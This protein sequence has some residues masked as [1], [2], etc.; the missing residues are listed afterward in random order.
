MSRHRLVLALLACVLTATA[1]AARQV[2]VPLHFDH[3]LIRQALVAQLYTS[4]S[5]KAILWDDGTGCGF[6]KLREPAVNSAGGR[7]RVVTRGEAR[8][9]TP[10]G[11]QCLA[12]LQWDGFIEVL[13]DPQISTD[14][15]VLQFRVVESNVYDQ[16]LKKRFVTG[17]L[18]DIVKRYVQPRFEA[19]RIDL[20]A[21]AADLRDVLPLIVARGDAERIASILDSIHLADATVNDTGVT[22]AL[23][24]AVSDVAP[25]AGPTPEPTLTAT[26]LQRWEEAW[27]RWDAFLTFVVKQLGHDTAATDLH[28]AL[29]DVLVDAR[30]D[31]LEALAP[32]QPGEPDP[33]RALFLKTWERLAPVVKRSAATM[34]GTAALRY[35]SFIAAGDALAALDQMGPDVGLDISAD[36]LR[37]LARIV[38]PLN[39]EDPLAYTTAVDPDLRQLFGFG[40]PLPPPD[41]SD[42]PTDQAW[43]HQLLGSTR[44]FAAE[45]KPSLKGL[46][47]WIADREEID[48]YLQA[49]HDVL[50]ETAHKTLG[51]SNLEERYRDV[52][53][54]LVLAA[55]WQESCWRQ[56]VRANGKVTYMKSAVGS[57]GM[58]QVNEHVWRGFYDLR[59]LRWDIHYNGRAGAEILMRYLQDYAIAHDEDKQPGGI[60]NLARATY[61]VYNGGPGQLTRY[62]KKNEKKTLQRIDKLF[63]EKYQAVSAG[64]EMDVSR[65]IVGG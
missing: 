63:W 33:T 42:E 3:E 35:L 8:V 11:D 55:A 48:T 22:I 16:E 36:G 5:G 7:I 10:V 39:A 62:R 38:V 57:T 17:K 25:A 20:N 53:R 18:W 65:C 15:K 2:T 50:D 40:T 27:Q 60:D 26:E 23:G 19:V 12:P 56:F 28:Q 41:L 47:R 9:G 54:H 21:P 4:P 13:E 58:M 49:V 1:A 51:S 52:Y 61:A 30:F 6:L 14:Q 37:R 34:P 64:K 43:W 44:A 32:S 46:E 31:I 29:L 59:G 45:D 24:F